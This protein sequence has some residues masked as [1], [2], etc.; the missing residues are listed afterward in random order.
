MYGANKE[1]KENVFEFYLLS[2]MYGAN[3]II[4]LSI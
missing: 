4:N 2:P 3:N 1:I